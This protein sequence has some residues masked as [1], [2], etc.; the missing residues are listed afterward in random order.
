LQPG[1]ERVAALHGRAFPY[2]PGVPVTQD[3]ASAVAL[4]ARE[5]LLER[6]ASLIAH[7]CAWAVGLSD[8]P[9]LAR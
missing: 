9:H 5:L 7:S 8:R 6:R 4:L 3:P 1:P 2:A